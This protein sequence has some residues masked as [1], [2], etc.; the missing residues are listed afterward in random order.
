MQLGLNGK[1][2]LVTGSSKG[3]GLAIADSLS[4]E[5]AIVI[6]NGRNA[7]ESTDVNP[8]HSYIPADVTKPDQCAVLLNR[9][10]AE[11]GR[12]DVLVCNVGSGR[13][14]PPGNEDEGEWLRMLH[15]NLLAAANMVKAATPLLQESCGSIV[16]VSSIC[17]VEALGCPLAYGASKAA[18][19]SYVRGA[20]RYLGK[21]GVRINAVAPGNILFPGSV[22]DT[23][24]RD[25]PDAVTEMLEREV[26]LGRLGRVNEIADVVSFLSSARA[27]FITGAIYVVDGGQV[28]S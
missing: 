28:R 19:N 7:R 10:S 21:L 17:G 18:L 8:G 16:C 2:A 14:L 22:W 5:G 13:S 26:S 11:W 23:K 6:A 20:A 12:L 24:S 25:M 1:V 9:V 27:S 3:I 15:L 4:Q